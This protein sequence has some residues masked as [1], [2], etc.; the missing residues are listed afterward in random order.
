M[1]IGMVGWSFIAIL[2]CTGDSEKV[3]SAPPAESV[4]EPLTPPDPADGFQFSFKTTVEPYTEIWKCSVYPAPYDELSPVNWLEYRVTPG[5]HHMT[6]ATP[7]LMES[8]L[9]PGVY[10]CKE[11]LE[12]QMRRKKEK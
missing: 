11:L 4:V 8:L 2:A 10:D 12:E 3:D 9:E 7:S 6:I 1:G 5:L